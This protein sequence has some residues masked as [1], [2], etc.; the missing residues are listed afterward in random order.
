[1]LQSG[2]PTNIIGPDMV[3]LRDYASF[4]VFWP[5]KTRL[6]NLNLTPQVRYW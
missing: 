5:A 2:V 3:I 6:V 4:L 1:M